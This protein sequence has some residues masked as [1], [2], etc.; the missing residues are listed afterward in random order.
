MLKRRHLTNLRASPTTASVGDTA[1]NTL[2]DK[3]PD[4]RYISVRAPSSEEFSF[5]VGTGSLLNNQSNYE[6]SVS[7]EENN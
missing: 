7:R 3:Q 5:C 1:D 2:T 4:Y 6:F